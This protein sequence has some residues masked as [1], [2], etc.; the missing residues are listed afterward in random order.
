MLKYSFSFP[1]NLGLA[2]R[3]VHNGRGFVASDSPVDDHIDLA[4]Q[5]FMD[6][7]RVRQILYIVVLIIGNGRRQ[8]GCSQLQTEFAG[9][10]IVGNA[11]AHLL[12]VAEDLGQMAAGVE[13][14]RERSGRMALEQFP[15]RVDS[16]L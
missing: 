5:P 11:D 13:D 4:A 9:D 1:D 10:R 16:D 14:E 8:Q 2:I 12:A 3:A 7:F 6:E 15:G